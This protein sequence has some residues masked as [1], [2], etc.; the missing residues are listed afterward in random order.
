[1][2][3]PKFDVEQLNKSEQKIYSVMTDSE[4]QNFERTWV[5]LELCK[6]KLT[7]QKNASRVR[8]A[9]E[10]KFLVEKE[11]KVRTHRLIERGAILESLIENPLDFTND[12]L[13]ILLEKILS[14]D[15]A[16]YQ[17]EYWRHRKE[18]SGDVSYFFIPAI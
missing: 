10:K 14:S 2:E 12:E 9:R 17:L 11:R 4:K 1:M 6:L 8:A 18:S 15:V 5:Q 13:K 7:Q 16:R 3:I